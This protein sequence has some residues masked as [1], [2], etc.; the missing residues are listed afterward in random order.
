MNRRNSYLIGLAGCT[1]FRL[2]SHAVITIVI[3]IVVIIIILL[4]FIKTLLKINDFHHYH[5]HLNFCKF[6][7]HYLLHGLQS[8]IFNTFF[9]CLIFIA[10]DT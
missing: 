7:E 10:S 6:Y 4:F 5:S 8:L 1:S 9:D 2:H 3:I